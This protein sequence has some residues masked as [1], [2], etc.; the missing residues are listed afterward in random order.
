MAQKKPVAPVKNK[1]PVN[2]PKPKAPQRTIIFSKRNYMLL[3]AS[4]ALVVLGFVLM[5]G[6]TDIYDARKTVIAPI[7]VL[8]GLALG[9]VAIMY[10][11]QD[12]PVES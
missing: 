10:K 12:A 6:K 1:K 5:Y 3:L 7:V 9:I 8:A 11:G 4:I 2:T